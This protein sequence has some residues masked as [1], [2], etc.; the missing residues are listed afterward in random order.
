[1][2]VWIVMGCQEMDGSG[3]GSPLTVHATEALAKKAAGDFQSDHTTDGDDEICPGSAERL[4]TFGWCQR[5]G[6]LYKVDG[7]YTV[8]GLSIPAVETTPKIEASFAISEC[9]FRL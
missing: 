1:M 2:Q 5:C 4:S 6:V 8:D 9:G 3:I 7:P